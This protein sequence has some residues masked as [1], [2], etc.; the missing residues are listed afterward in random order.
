MKPQLPTP[1]NCCAC[2]ACVDV[3]TKQAIS[4]TEDENAFYAIRVKEYLCVGCGACERHCHLLHPETIS[5]HD[6]RDVHPLAGWSTNAEIIRRSASGGIFAQLAHH[7]L[8]R[9]NAYVY[10]ASLQEDS[11]VRHIEISRLEDLPLLQNA[12]YQQSLTGGIYRQVQT[13][14]E[15]GATVLFS[16]VPCQVA[17][18]YSYLGTK[19]RGLENL[20]TAE[21]ICHGVPTNELHR[22]ALEIEKARRIVAY[23]T[24][25]GTGWIGNNNRLT[26]EMKDGTI[27][28]KRKHVYDFLF[29]AYLQFSFTRE[30][31]LHCPY[32]QLSR[33]S[34]LTLGDFWGWNK[35]P[36]ASEYRNHDGISVIL[37]NS[38]RGLQL[39]TECED[40]HLVPTTWR[41]ILPAN[42][43]LYMPT[44]HYLFRG[45]GKV[46]KIRR[47]PLSIQRFIYQNGFSNRYLNEAYR[48]T[49]S[50]L[51][52]PWTSAKDRE[53]QR[54]LRDALTIFSSPSG[55]LDTL[56]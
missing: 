36:R 30:N 56:K 33:V 21:V 39:L 11:T 19:A 13:R 37:P 52:W 41:E 54:K 38:K 45:A 40:L 18:L 28:A 44:N 43:N 48:R 1:D 24:K 6:A 8:R 55:I 35:S 5:R 34:D 32:A 14:L 7:L 42:Q 51:L 10:G 17:A 31:C 53:Q 47:L 27:Q 9:G 46:K 50:L 20:Y 2:G 4:F 49:M 16:G 25:E 29:R 15:E 26:Y 12:K 22:K 23:R 3:C